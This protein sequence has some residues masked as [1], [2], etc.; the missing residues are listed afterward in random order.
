MATK[1]AAVAARLTE[2]EAVA[3]LIRNLPPNL[4]IAPS[5]QPELSVEELTKRYLA[6]P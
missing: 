5:R 4:M 6:T 2:I 1:F 3:Q